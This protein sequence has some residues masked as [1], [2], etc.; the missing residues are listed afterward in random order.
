[1]ESLELPLTQT[2][3][4]FFSRV[5]SVFVVVAVVH[6]IPWTYT[7]TARLKEYYYTHEQYRVQSEGKER[8]GRKKILQ[9]FHPPKKKF[10]PPFFLCV[11]LHILHGFFPSSRVVGVVRCAM[12]E[13]GNF[14]T[15]IKFHFKNE[16]CHWV[17][18][19][20]WK[21]TKNFAMR[22]KNGSGFFS[23]KFSTWKIDF[24]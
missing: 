23:K 1:M 20:Q 19:M 5:V 6:D 11:K 10:F 4:N 3:I 24:S 15:L 16:K 9:K 21:L 2:Y 13:E 17:L 14:L 8:K 22:Q 7:C 18:K 12:Y